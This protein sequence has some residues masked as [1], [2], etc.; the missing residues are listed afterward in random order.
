M[1]PLELNGVV[2]RLE[3]RHEKHPGIDDIYL[4]TIGGRRYHVDRTVGP[5]L[6]PGA[7]ITK[8]R[9]SKLLETSDGTVQLRASR[10][11]YSMLVAMPVVAIVGFL[12]MSSRDG[13]M[14]TRRVNQ[15]HPA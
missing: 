11:A 14:T 7:E 2:S 12:L 5:R 1:I 13:A 15:D 8:R 9:W 3:I 6:L 10:D 4:V